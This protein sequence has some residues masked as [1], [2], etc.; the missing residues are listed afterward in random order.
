[1]STLQIFPKVVDSSNYMADDLS[2]TQRQ[3]READ[4]L[5]AS[6]KAQEAKNRPNTPLQENFHRGILRESHEIFLT[7]R[8][9]TV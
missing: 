3:Q 1:V 5:Q 7:P 9:T 2:E 6:T 4:A 8:K